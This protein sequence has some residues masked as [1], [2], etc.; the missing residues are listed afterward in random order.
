[1]RCLALLQTQTAK[2]F[3]LHT[4]TPG[5]AEF[6][7]Y[8]KCLFALSVRPMRV[9]VFMQQFLTAVGL[10]RIE[11]KP[12]CMVKSSSLCCFAAL[13]T[14]RRLQARVRPRGQQLARPQRSSI[15]HGAT[16]SANA[17]CGDQKTVLHVFPHRFPTSS[18]K[19]RKTRRDD[20]QRVLGPNERALIAASTGPDAT[21]F[22]PT[23][24]YGYPSI[25]FEVLRSG[26]IAAVTLFEG[27]AGLLLGAGGGGG[28]VAS[29]G[30][31]GGL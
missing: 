21:P 1:M 22:G 28:G 12:P 13:S 14:A 10:C 9:S 18:A 19:H 31:G 11:I 4:N 20:V 25:A 26:R 17:R 5:H 6:S 16:L 8:A 23:Y 2:K 3:V 7:I 29:A 15:L 24:V 27:P 30:V